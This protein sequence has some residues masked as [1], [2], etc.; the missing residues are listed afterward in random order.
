MEA[1]AEELAA[2]QALFAPLCR[3]AEQPRQAAHYLTGQ[4]L[5]LECK[6][7]ERLAM[8]VPG[9]NVEALQ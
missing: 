4:L 3:R 7:I 8:T 1:L 9:G 6:S 2:Y 5:D